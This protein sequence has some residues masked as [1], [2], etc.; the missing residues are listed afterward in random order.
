MRSSTIISIFCLSLCLS[1]CHPDGSEDAAASREN[2]DRKLEPRKVS[3][4]QPEVREERPS[5]ALVGEVRAFDTVVIS[6]E[7]AGRVERVNVEVGDKVSGGQPLVSVARET[8]EMKLRQAE[9]RVQAA[10]ADLELARRD[11]E[12]K[13][14]LVSDK[15]I[16]QAAFEQAQARHDLAAAGLLE[17]VAA[18]DLAEHDF[19]VSII[20][21][22]AAGA[23]T[24][25]V[26][27]AGQWADIGQALLE[28]A[29]GTQV[30]IVAR[31]PSHWVTNL[32]G[33][34]GFD[35]SVDPNQPARRAKLYSIDP[36]VQEASRSFEVVGTA[37]AEK[38]KPGMFANV[39][40]TSPDITRSLW[41][42]VSA[43]LTSDTPKVYLA[44]DGRVAVRR[45]Q[46]GLRDDGMIEVVSGIEPFEKVIADV[47]GLSRDLPVNV[48]E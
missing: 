18:R 28:M 37:P 31:V 9:A 48:V 43:V 40:L 47:A 22:P 14:D 20:R 19:K 10:T 42:P 30:K 17:S 15:T 13:Q 3:E 32:Q 26:V 36:V 2:L 44:E 33:L 25:R 5:V 46:T 21:A 38:L 24:G 16:P 35:F 41:L 23:I 7:V 1:A 29:V 4:V 39:T 27:V 8:F 6:S 34:D 11:L 45:I 12:R